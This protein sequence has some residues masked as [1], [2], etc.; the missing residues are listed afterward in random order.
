MLQKAKKGFVLQ[1]SKFDFILYIAT[2]L[3][4]VYYWESQRILALAQLPELK[5]VD[6]NNIGAQFKWGG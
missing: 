4:I 3:T 2:S 1:P 6:P 5:I